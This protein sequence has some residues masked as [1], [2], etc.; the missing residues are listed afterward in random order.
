MTCSCRTPCIHT[1]IA[2]NSVCKGCWRGKFLV[3][4][5]TKSQ[6][7]SYSI[8][9]RALILHQRPKV[10]YWSRMPILKVVLTLMILQAAVNVHDNPSA[11]IPHCVLSGNTTNSKVTDSVSSARAV[12]KCT[13]DIIMQDEHMS[14]CCVEI[15]MPTKSNSL[16]Y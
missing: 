2:P 8:K 6:A 10:Q 14:L 9:Q 5:A 11:D 7:H 16:E 4:L 13:D 15:D 12:L 3:L 1:I